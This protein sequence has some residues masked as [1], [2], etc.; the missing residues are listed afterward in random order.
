MSDMH[1]TQHSCGR[2]P[3]C[4]TPCLP[5]ATCPYL[6]PPHLELALLLLV[7]TTALRRGVLRLQLSIVVPQALQRLARACRCL[8]ARPELLGCVRKAA[9]GSSNDR[10]CMSRRVSWAA[11]DTLQKLQPRPQAGLLG[12]LAPPLSCCG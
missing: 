6:P 10:V 11:K 4:R 7:A 3:E 9:Q 1:T 2:D 8:V 5:S 12:H